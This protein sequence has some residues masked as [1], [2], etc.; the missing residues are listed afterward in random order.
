MSEMRFD[1][2]RLVATFSQRA[3]DAVSSLMHHAE[4]GYMAR[5]FPFLTII[6]LRL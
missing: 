5:I 1:A 4:M 6:Q 3:G 2:V